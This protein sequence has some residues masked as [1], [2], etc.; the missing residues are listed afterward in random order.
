[1]AQTITLGKLSFLC[2]RLPP[3]KLWQ[4]PGGWT[5][6]LSVLCG[7]A[8]S[9]FCE[10]RWLS[11]GLALSGVRGITPAAQDQC[12]GHKGW[13]WGPWHPSP[14]VVN[15]RRE[16]KP[17]R[18]LKCSNQVLWVISSDPCSLVA[19]WPMLCASLRAMAGWALYL[20]CSLCW[21]YLVDKFTPTWFTC[22]AGYLLIHGLECPF[23]SEPSPSP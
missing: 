21:P 4:G 23:L 14:F 12:W 19:I 22:Q 18:T 17:F 13:A 8:P 2:C 11:S 20:P 3:S 1:M 7:F 5:S 10:W 15:K 6:S 16:P 9:L